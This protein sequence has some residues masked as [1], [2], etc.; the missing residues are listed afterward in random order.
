[1][2]SD[3]S[4]KNRLQ[5]CF[6][7]PELPSCTDQSDSGL[8]RSVWSCHRAPAQTPTQ[9]GRLLLAVRR[10]STR[11]L[12]L[13][14]RAQTSTARDLFVDYGQ[15]AVEAERSACAGSSRR[16]LLSR[17]GRAASVT[18]DLS[19]PWLGHQLTVLRRQG[20]LPHRRQL[21]RVVPIRGTSSLSRYG[22]CS[23]H[24]TSKPECSRARTGFVRDRLSTPRRQPPT[25]FVASIQLARE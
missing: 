13:R 5:R 15:A 11:L 16:T 25:R 12:L 1:M 6:V 8:I 9:A 10:P 2:S 24:Q 23:R 4:D 7:A 3:R 22:S 18:V 17:R 19:R 20:P 21:G 14:V